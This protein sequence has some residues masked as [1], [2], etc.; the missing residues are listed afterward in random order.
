[1]CNVERRWRGRSYKKGGARIRELRARL[2]T[3]R[4]ATI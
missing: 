4:Y 2:L 3:L 1:M